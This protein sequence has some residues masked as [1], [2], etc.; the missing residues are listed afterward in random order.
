MIR[1]DELDRRIVEKLRRDAR[2]SNRA[3]AAELGVT[4]GTIRSR[5]KRLQTDGLIQFTVVA[6]FRMSGSPNLCMIGIDADPARVTQLARELSE[7]GEIGCVVVLLGRYS[8]LAM[9]LVTSV[10]ALTDLVADRIRPLEG[11]RRVETSIS[12]RN[13]KYDAGVAKISAMPD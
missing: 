6:D 12:V 10:E 4:E 2:V 3:I 13:L 1:L 11:V 7:I 9:T 8:I 5:I